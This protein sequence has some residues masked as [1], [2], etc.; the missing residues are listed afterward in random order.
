MDHIPVQGTFRML[1]IIADNVT[2]YGDG[3]HVCESSNLSNS[4]FLGRR[5][6]S[7]NRCTVL[8]LLQ[9]IPRFY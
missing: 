5:D 6:I 4:T 1:R 7:L 9:N 8:F 3:F 2:A